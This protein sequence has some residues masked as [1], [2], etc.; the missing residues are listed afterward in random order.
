MAVFFAA[1][2]F[3]VFCT[4]F[5]FLLVAAAVFTAD[6]FALAFF[7]LAFFERVRLVLLLAVP[8]IF[9]AVFFAVDPVLVV[10]FRATVPLLVESLAE[11]FF[12]VSLLAPVV[13][14]L[15]VDV[16]DVSR[17]CVALFR[18]LFALAVVFP[19][20]LLLRVPALLAVFLATI[21]YLP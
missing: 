13:A 8:E 16:F 1:G 4:G 10:A 19:R 2:F 20:V 6:F 5:V 3:L 17:V 21:C 14:V 11:A 15:R 7:A 18:V 9:D 12:E